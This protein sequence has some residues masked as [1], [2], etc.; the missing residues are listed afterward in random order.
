MDTRDLMIGDW[1]HYKVNLG[2]DGIYEKD[3]QIKNIYGCNVNCEVRGWEVI[4]GKRMADLYPIPLTPEILEKNGFYWGNTA[5]EEDFCGAVG[6][7]YPDCGWCFD[8]G[9]GE[10]KIIFPNET[11]G[12]LIRLD[13]QSA[14]RHLELIFVEP[15][16]V[17]ELQHAL[18]LCGIGKEI[19]L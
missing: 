12:G 10:I 16:A 4:S 9:A 14:D 8:E 11:D 1:V 3:V 17:H 6:C 5:T 18:R 2:S 13:D 15:I 7:G 19:V